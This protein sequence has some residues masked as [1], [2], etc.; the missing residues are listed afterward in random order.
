[1]I[2][3]HNLIEIELLAELALPIFP[4]TYPSPNPAYDSLSSTE[5]CCGFRLMVAAELIGPVRD[6]QRPSPSADKGAS[7]PFDE[8]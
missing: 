2:R 5:R 6:E 1:V 8:L 4:P 3:R 7:Q